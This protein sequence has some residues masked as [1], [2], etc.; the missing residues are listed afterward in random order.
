MYGFM[1]TF[2]FYVCQYWHEF[3]RFIES[4]IKAAKKAGYYDRAS[5]GS[6]EKREEGRIIN[7]SPDGFAWGYGG[8]GPAD[9]ALNI[10]AIFIGQA[11]AVKYY[12]DFKWDFIATLPYE[13]GVIKRED[14]LQWIKG[15]TG[16]CMG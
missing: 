4:V 8:S 3:E 5:L 6:R 10:L 15:R 16:G 9:L 2:Y 14:I 12:Q 7:H 11:E 1:A 13:G